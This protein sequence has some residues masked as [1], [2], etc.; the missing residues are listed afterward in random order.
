MAIQILSSSAGAGKTFNLAKTYIRLLLESEDIFAYRHILAVTF[1]NKATAEMKNR[2]L[3]E[4][5]KLAENPGES[6]YLDDFSASMGGRDK[7]QQKASRVLSLILNDYGA[8]S[9]STIDRFFQVVLRAFARE[10]GRFPDYRIELDRKSL[11]RESVDRLLDSLGGGEDDLLRKWIFSGALESIDDKGRFALEKN[12][13]DMAEKVCGDDYSR[14]VDENGIIPEL[15]CSRENISLAKEACRRVV[16]SFRE[17]IKVSA[18]RIVELFAEA[19]VSPEDFSNADKFS[20]QFPLYASALKGDKFPTEAFLRRCLDPSTWFRK[21]SKVDMQRAEEVLAGPMADFAALFTGRD[22]AVYNTAV[23]IQ[24]QMNTLGLTGEF[25]RSLDDLMSEKNI[26]SIDR[27]NHTLKDIIAGSDAPFVYEKIGVRYENFLLDE[28]Q[29]TSVLQWENF[30]PLLS[31][32]ES[33][34]GYSLL[35]GDV[36]QS[37]YRWRGGDWRLLSEKVERDFPSAE[38]GR[39][40]TDNY[41][42]LKAIVEYNNAFFAYAAEVLDALYASKTGIDGWDL[43]R[44]IYA[45]VAQTPKSRESAPGQIVIAEASEDGQLEDVLRAVGK[46]LEN[47]ARHADIAVLVRGNDEGS[48]IALYLARAGIPV[49]SDDSMRVKSSVSVHRLLSLLGYCTGRE[50]AIG[51]YLAEGIGVEIPEAYES[52]YDL[53]EALSRGLRRSAPELFA[54]ESV[55]IQAFMDVL[56]EW[57]AQRGNSIPEF[58]EYFDGIDPKISSPELAD[59][60]RVIT[61]HKA[62]GLEF[63]YVIFPYAE[64]V[65]LFK[66]D[67]M[68]CCPDL[69]GTALE[70]HAKNAYDINVSSRLE[71]SLFAKDYVKELELQYIDNLNIFYVAM[72]RASRVLHV[73]TGSSGKDIPAVPSTM[74][75]ILLEF[76]KEK[77]PWHGEEYFFPKE[78]R[79]GGVE[80]LPAVFE[81]YPLN[82]EMSLDGEVSDARVSGRL[83]L[84]SDAVDFFSPEGEAGTE[85]SMRLKGI[86]LHGILSSCRTEDDL[87]NAVAAACMAGKVESSNKESY[88]GFLRGALAGVRELGWFAREGHRVLEERDILAPDGTL[89]R[90]DRVLVGESGR[91][92]VIDYKFGAGRPS[93]RRQVARYCNLFR[94]MGYSDVEGWLW[95]VGE[96]TERVV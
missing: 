94:E 87:E 11:V 29:D 62:K 8:F 47:G 21:N 37:I 25:I 24:G 38:R 80:V 13:Y 32:S 67:S 93:Y 18:G 23:L 42:S 44:R 27:T 57:S 17:S 88:L 20:N 61:I 76:E 3:G 68:W 82:D 45:D 59:A 71:G 79:E 5:F 54:S 55:Y 95:Y 15:S 73:I 85:A 72:T 86:V 90:P 50:D 28:F 84:R 83:K 41:R 39:P 35:V 60:V 58:L 26:L 31:E 63:P 30:R 56:S 2:I 48:E 64:K 12:L 43:A 89:H 1:T 19:G 92:V 78:S 46:A 9:V 4:L 14:V 69:K 81:S 65:K 75:D 33:S 16:S 34:G 52:L 36:K 91:V 49:I 22:M 53:A 66:N 77:A 70:E 10:L 40:L 7:V 74:A 6:Q 96:R 51:K